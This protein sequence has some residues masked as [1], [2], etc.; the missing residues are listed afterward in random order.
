MIITR[1]RLIVG[2]LTAIGVLSGAFAQAPALMWRFYGTP[3]PNNPAAP[4][5]SD[6]TAYYTCLNRLFAVHLATGALKWQYPADTPLDSTFTTRPVIANGMVY[7]GTGN[8]NLLAMDA[9]T[10]RLRWT[11]SARS[12]I[13]STP[14][15]DSDNIYF[16]TGT[17]DFFALDAQSGE[18]RW[19]KPFKAGGFITGDIHKNEDM[20]IFAADD[21]NVYG[22]NTSGVGRWRQAIPS[23]CYDPR[24]SM[25]EN[26]IYATGS[27]RLI[28]FNARSGGIRFQRPG[29]KSDFRIGPAADES[30][31]YVINEN[32][33]FAFDHTGRPI[34]DLKTPAEL[35]HDAAFAPTASGGKLWVTTK[36]GTLLAFDGSTSTLIWSYTLRPLPLAPGVQ[37]PPNRPDYIN[38]IRSPFPTQNGVLVM[39][40]DGSLNMFSS[41]WIDRLAP[42]V[43][44]IFPSMGTMMS[45]QLP[46][47]FSL[48]LRDDGSGI[49]GST[50]K[51]LLNGEPLES[52][53][54][55]PKGLLEVRMR[56]SSGASVTKP[57]PDG[58]H[59]L[60][61]EATDWAGNTL[62]QSWAIYV[63]NT[64]SRTPPRRPTGNP[65]GPGGGGRDGGGS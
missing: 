43:T 45:G 8:G 18:P 6:D 46:L 36:R 60:T 20:L 59:T 12:G 31:V 17:G 29:F 38:I 26:T 41:Q 37:P 62:R 44:Q 7:I 27:N 24:I 14:A 13:T 50:V 52:V 28:A 16:G 32:K 30:G 47:D 53:F 63:D 42:E 5:A 21:N 22:V 1:V 15:A 65:G 10:G 57:L 49:N 2:W 61:I 56:A 64:L 51:L 55:E 4:S 3:A 33:I 54:D 11:F 35:P 19:S 58:R 23:P 40:D 39:G 9:A 48:R 25:A 34:S